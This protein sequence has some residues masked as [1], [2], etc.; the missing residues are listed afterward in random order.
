[1]QFLHSYAL[2]DMIEEP[3]LI[4]STVPSAADVASAQ[5]MP[6]LRGVLSS[7]REDSQSSQFRLFSAH[8]AGVPIAV[9]QPSELSEPAAREM[10]V[11]DA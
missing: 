9:E 3:I 4:T 1:M 11:S 10:L 5:G 8:S 2:Q 6:D 7:R